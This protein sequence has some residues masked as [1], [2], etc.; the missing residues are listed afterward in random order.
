MSFSRLRVSRPGRGAARR[1]TAAPDTAPARKAI[2]RPVAELR[3]VSFTADRL[4]PRLRPGATVRRPAV[5][6]SVGRHA[7][8]LRLRRPRIVAAVLSEQGPQTRGDC[9]A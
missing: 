5:S 2:T 6:R 1:A 4:L 8:V 9:R 3:W 7:L